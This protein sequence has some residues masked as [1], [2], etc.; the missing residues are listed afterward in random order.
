MLWWAQNGPSARGLR[1]YRARTYATSIGC[2]KKGRRGPSPEKGRR[3]VLSLGRAF[4]VP[5]E[6][7]E[8]FCGE[9]FLK[10][11][12]ARVRQGHSKTTFG[13]E[14]SLLMRFFRR[15]PRYLFIVGFRG[16]MVISFNYHSAS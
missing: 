6:S 1:G 2:R 8:T 3:S 16:G 10:K 7:P 4:V 15:D 5:Q 13:L 14:Q 12:R 11:A 9:T